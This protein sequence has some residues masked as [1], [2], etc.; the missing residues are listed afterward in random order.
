VKLTL[1]EVVQHILSSLDGDEVSSIT[2]TT[3]SLQVAN[4]VKG[5]Y[6]DI[7]SGLDLPEKY[8][9]YQITQ[10]SVTTPIVMTLPAKAES[11]EWLKYNTKLS[12]DSLPIFKDMIFMPWNDYL[13]RQLSLTDD[14]DGTVDTF[15]YTNADSETWTIAYRNDLMPQY[16]STPDDHTIFLD[17]VNTDE[18]TFLHT[19]RT[20]AYG[21]VVETWDLDDDFDF[22]PLDSEQFS[23]LVNKAK[24]R[25]FAELK[26]TQNVNAMKEA[27]F[28]LIHQQRTNKAIRDP[29]IAMSITPNFGRRPR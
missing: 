27:R 4:V 9:I 29:K 24:D 6:M 25:A 28:Q 10:T 8:Q 7:M 12:T 16:Y 14:S 18:E 2:D 19:T 22:S 1:L 5:V 3:E 15:T 11:L 26:Q 20:M 21:K 17:S 13:L 23:L